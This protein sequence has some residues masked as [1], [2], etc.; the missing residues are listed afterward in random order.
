MRY[1]VGVRKYCQLTKKVKQVKSMSTFNKEM[2]MPKSKKRNWIHKMQSRSYYSGQSNVSWYEAFE[3]EVLTPQEE[4]VLCNI[5]VSSPK[6][7]KEYLEAY[8]KLVNQNLK[9]VASE[10]ANFSAKTGIDIG[11][12]INEGYFG[13]AYAVDKYN[14]NHSDNARFATY[15]TYWINQKIRLYITRN[16]IAHVPT[17][18]VPLVVKYKRLL[19]DSGDKKLT[20][21]EIMKELDIDNKTLISIEM[22]NIQS[23]SIFQ[24]I[25]GES[26]RNEITV[27]ETLREE[28]IPNPYEHACNED[29]NKH[30]WDAVNSLSPRAKDIIMSQIMN[31][32]KVNLKE[33]G[34]K[35]GFSYERI[36]Q[37]RNEALDT[38]RIKLI[39]KDYNNNKNY[40]DCEESEEENSGEEVA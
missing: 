9:L 39:K 40:D 4:R 3:H 15:A 28:K 32:E 29:N 33:I 10:A 36:R 31:D 8:D 16:T 27:A 17:Y 14:P 12:L 1:C 6:D 21:K 7:S 35:Y 34:V 37:L 19:S 5:I 30:I 2:K 38:I 26:D 22:A 13:L 24:V 20:R 11:D 18:L 25:E 23:I